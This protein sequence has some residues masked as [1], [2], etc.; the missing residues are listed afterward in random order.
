M[1]TVGLA[2]YRV[3]SRTAAPAN[4]RV[5]D[6]RAHFG[7]LGATVRFSAW[8][9]GATLDRL[10]D[11]DHASVLHAAAGDV[12]RCGWP[13]VDTEVTFNEW[14]ERG[15]IDF[16]GAHEIARAILVGEAKSAWGSLEE[17][18]RTLDVK[19]RLAPAI[20][21]KRYGWEPATIGAV[22]AFPEDAQARRIA[23]E[24]AR[25]L[26]AGYP[27]RNREV[28]SWLRA[29]DGPLRGLWFLSI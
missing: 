22:L 4:F 23:S 16:L 11:A 18:R 12:V 21:A 9:D 26:L 27:A 17:T 15:S 5:N 29:P 7:K 10:I 14:G 20:A 19:V 24:Y 13:R 8:Y 2:T 3:S 25:T 1:G 6:L 28:R